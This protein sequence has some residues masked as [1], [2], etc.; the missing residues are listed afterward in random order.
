[1]NEKIIT[2]F[3]AIAFDLDGVL[4]EEP[5]SWWTLHEAFGTYEK[6]SRPLLC[7]DSNWSK[8]ELNVN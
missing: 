7:Y 1:M 4:V 5:S 8:M 2:G 3:Q 6:G